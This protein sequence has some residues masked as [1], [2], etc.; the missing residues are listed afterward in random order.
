VDGVEVKWRQP[1]AQQVHDPVASHHADVLGLRDVLQR[2]DLAVAHSH[3]G[4]AQEEA[5]QRLIGLGAVCDQQVAVPRGTH[6][7]VEDH[8]EAADHDVLQPHRLGVGYD[9]R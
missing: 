8:A 1:T 5:Q 6:V 4:H 3:R 9:A 7:A 2:E